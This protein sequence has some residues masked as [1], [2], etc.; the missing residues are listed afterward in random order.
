MWEF[1]IQD[2]TTGEIT[3]IFG[4]NFYDACR[5]SKLNPMDWDVLLQ[6]YID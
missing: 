2:V 1:E 4:Y 3:L 5:R 6:T